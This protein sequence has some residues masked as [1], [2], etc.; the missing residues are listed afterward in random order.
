M[1]NAT[2]VRLRFLRDLEENRFHDLPGE[3][4]VRGFLKAYANQLGLDSKDV[5]KRYLEQRGEDTQPLPFDRHV[6]LGPI[7]QPK[8]GGTRWLWI[9]L[10]LAVLL[11]IISQLPLGPDQVVESELPETVMASR[12]AEIPLSS[13][14]AEVIP[15][16]Q[17]GKLII[18]AVKPTTLV[19][20]LD[21]GR[22]MQHDLQ[23]GQTL[24]Y[25]IE[26]QASFQVTELQSLKIIFGGKEFGILPT[27]STRFSLVTKAESP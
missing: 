7:E 12:T 22:T 14:D 10:G 11:L 24:T 23:T 17:V 2:R 9:F 26:K 8:R 13:T 15:A 18:E 20:T 1:A 16:D 25:T 3:V 6:A 19:L 5:M 4:F 21:A 27:S